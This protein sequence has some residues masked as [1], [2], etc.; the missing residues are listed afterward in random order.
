MTR[1]KSNDHLALDRLA[2]SLVDDI[3]N[4]T[5]EEML[6]EITA[7]GENPERIA[8]EARDIFERA[9]MTCRK[10]KLAAA[11]KA[12]LLDRQQSSKIFQLDPSVARQKLDKILKQH[13]ETRNK[14][15]LAARNEGGLSDRDIFSM[16]Q[17]LEEL[18][19]ISPLDKEDG[20]R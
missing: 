15:T 8:Q 2:E 6:A 3:L 11:K 7:D 17:D 16:L 10:A 1:D 5:D 9:V 19:V 12:V 4:M 13:P 18:G 20:N 14:L